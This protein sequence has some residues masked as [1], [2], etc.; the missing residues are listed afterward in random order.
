VSRTLDI[1]GFPLRGSQLVEAS[2]G[3]GK[4]WTIGA[5]YLRLVL[6]HGG[7]AAF[8]RPLTPPEILVVTFTD[9][10]TKEL[11]DR[12]RARLAQAALAFA[13]EGGAPDPLLRQLRDAWPPDQWPDC[14]R[15]LRL[16]AEWMD[17]A[18]VSTIHG[19]CQRMLREHAFDSGSLFTQALQADADGARLQAARDWW[20]SHVYPLQPAQAAVLAGWWATPDVLARDLRSLLPQAHGLPAGAPPRQALEDAAAARARAVAALKAPWP[21]WL[22]TLEPLLETACKQ[23][24]QARSLGKRKDWL[25]KLRDWAAGEAED[26]GLSDTAYLRLSLA[27]LDARLLPG[28]E[29]VRHPALDAL[30]A[31]P[32]QLA[33][34]PDG[35]AQVLAQATHWVA[36]R[37]AGEKARRAEIGFD[38]MLSQLARA[39][40]G[41]G[42]ERLAARIRQQFPVALIDEF[43]DTDTLQWGIFDAVWQAG[44]DR[45]D[46]ALVL[47]GDPKQAIYSFRGADIHSYLAAKAATAPRHHS[48]GTNHRAS[49][50]M[51]AAVN[52]LFATA[53]QRPGGAFLFGAGDARPVPFEPVAA[54]GRAEVFEVEDA[55]PPALVC[56][57]AASGDGKA[58]GATAYRE[59]MA[60]ACAAEVVRLL[61]LGRDG[62][63][64]FRRDGVLQPLHPGDIAVLVN[65]RVEADAVRT[66]L[67]RLGVRSVYLSDDESVYRQP[68][69]D[70]LRRLLEAVAEPDDEPLVRAALATPLLGQDWAALDALQADPLAWE[71]MVLRFQQ[72]RERWRRHGVLPMLRQLLAQFG[73]PHRLLAAGDERQL[74]DVL[75]LAELLQQASA[76]LDGEQALVRHLAE[77]CAQAGSAGEDARV[78]RLESDADLLKVVTVHKSKGLEYPLVFLPFPCA[79]RAVAADDLSVAW[80]GPDGALQVSLQPTAGQVARADDERLAE[81]LRKLYVALTR[82]R[83]A[84]WVGL[85]PVVD[86]Q[87]SAIGHLLAGPEPLPPAAWPDWL[88]ALALRQPAIARRDPPE[89]GEARW[90][91]L[92]LPATWAEEPPLPAARPRWAITSY[93][94]LALADA[95]P[96]ADAARAVAAVEREEAG[97][98]V[99]P[100]PLAQEPASGTEA[101]WAEEARLP[102]DAPPAAGPVARTGLHALPRGAA[103]GTFLHELLEWAGRTGYAALAA[104]PAELARGVEQRCRVRGWERWTPTLTAWLQDWLARPWPLARAGGGVP[105]TAPTALATVQVELEFWLDA[106][107]LDLAALDALVTRHTLGG[108]PRRPLLPGEVRGLLKGFVDLAFGHGGRWW[109]ADWKSNALGDDDGA[110]TPEALRA[111]MLRHRYDLQVALYLFALHRQLRARLPGYDWDRDVGG[112]VWLFLRG[113]GGPGAGLHLERPPRA[114]VEGLDRLFDA[115]GEEAA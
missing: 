15:R 5:L 47:I 30:A 52:T 36:A 115:A 90:Q 45:Q 40:R 4:T 75:H 113:Q 94:G 32:A 64:G 89:P 76:T 13:Q 3:T 71:A 50:A 37:M 112:A 55:A 100:L 62:R 11:R 54:A 101:T 39:L 9:A 77:Q 70:C 78:L 92:Q 68:V 17:E 2:A 65:K 110:Y 66:A 41:E 86:L 38:D 80:H 25:G 14:A 93:S 33:A 28:A 87:R 31:L 67:R 104:Q 99:D 8:A 83:H 19:W 12:I 51:V 109:V 96:G 108:A 21:A 48:L 60:R 97:A 85:A 6:G 1:L 34:L 43:Q 88:D 102:A 74:T 91:D 73:V 44:A 106:P 95:L 56:W 18:A 58:M 29:P 114:L 22:D 61:R 35:R 24:L 16:A 84:T 69:A 7:E 107:Q 63:A 81:D 57:W 103:A 46:L 42:G 111:E 59:R 98:G 79:T 82:A 10:A 49:T 105:D 72:W 20:R 26:P 53:E 27:D 23:R